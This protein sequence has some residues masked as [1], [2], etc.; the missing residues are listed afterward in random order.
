V[1]SVVVGL[2][3]V[4]LAS[5]YLTTPAGALPPFLPGQELGSSDILVN[6]GLVSLVLS[7][8]LFAFAWTQRTRKH[9]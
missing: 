8:A 6:N 4:A 3:L 5:A 9:E 1:L 7:L 2:L